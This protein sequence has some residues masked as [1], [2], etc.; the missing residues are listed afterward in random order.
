[1]I[2]PYVE[3]G[4]RIEGVNSNLFDLHEE[5]MG[6]FKGQQKNKR[7]NIITGQLG[8]DDNPLHL[9]LQRFHDGT[10][11]VRLTMM[12]D[13]TD[14]PGLEIGALKDTLSKSQI[15]PLI[16]RVVWDIGERAES[17]SIHVYGLAPTRLEVLAERFFDKKIEVKKLVTVSGRKSSDIGLLEQLIK[18]ELLE[19]GDRQS[20][21]PRVHILNALEEGR[22]LQE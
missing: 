18:T 8:P 15:Q 1:M 4:R 20:M 3:L 12:T 21:V 2:Y 9:Q 6:L 22:D 16:T 11:F 7:T 5:L 14:H 17:T 13:T 19:N 10:P